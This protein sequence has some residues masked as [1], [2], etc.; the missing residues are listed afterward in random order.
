MVLCAAEHVGSTQQ[1]EAQARHQASSTAWGPH[2]PRAM[3]QVSGLLQNTQRSPHPWRKTRKRTPGPST[4]LKDSMLCTCTQDRGQGSPVGEATAPAREV[5]QWRPLHAE[6]A[7]SSPWRSCRLARAEKHRRRPLTEPTTSG[8]S[9]GFCGAAAAKSNPCLRASRVCRSSEELLM[10]SG[11]GWALVAAR[12]EAA[13][14]LCRVLSRGT[15]RGRSRAGP[16]L[17]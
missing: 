13:N 15:A 16:K 12:A 4:A 11:C 6:N 17:S 1:P 9:S 10:T 7:H 8:T 14:V 3:C 2:S 5:G